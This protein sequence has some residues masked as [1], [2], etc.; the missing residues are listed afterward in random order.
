MSRMVIGCRG[1]RKESCSPGREGAVPGQASEGGWAVGSSS[2][3]SR[4]TDAVRSVLAG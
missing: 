4:S 1:E 2:R 3:V